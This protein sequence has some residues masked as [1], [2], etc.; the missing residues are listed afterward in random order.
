MQTNPI[1]LNIFESK[2]KALAN[3]VDVPLFLSL[4]HLRQKINTFPLYSAHVVSPHSVRLNTHAKTGVDVTQKII[5]MLGLVACSWFLCSCTCMWGCAQKRACWWKKVSFHHHHLLLWIIMSPIK[6]DLFTLQ[7]SVATSD[8]LRIEQK[9]FPAA[10][11]SS[12]EKSR[13]ISQ[14]W[15]CLVL[16]T[17]PSNFTVLCSTRENQKLIIQLEISKS[18]LCSCVYSHNTLL[19]SYIVSRIC[20]CLFC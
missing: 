20:T 6:F 19:H 17:M 4:L 10:P 18:K 12:R 2:W 16:C 1:W 14:R 13:S 7:G 11:C 5:V 9:H 3:T 8:C 15:D